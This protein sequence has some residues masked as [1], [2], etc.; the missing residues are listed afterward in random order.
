MITSRF[1]KVAVTAAALSAPLLF[2]SAATATP[3]SRDIVHPD[4]FVTVASCSTFS[5]TVVYAPGLLKTTLRQETAT[6]SGTLSNC[7]N[8]GGALPGTGTVNGTLSGMSSLNA[9]NLSGSLVVSLPGTNPSVVS[10][11]LYGTNQA[12]DTLGGNVVSG[13]YTGGIFKTSVL[14]VGKTGTGS[15]KYPVTA[16]TLVNTTPVTVSQNFG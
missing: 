16:Q 8:S 1:V 11:L 10:A 9:V 3:A 2:A 6:I 5:G 14:G 7:Q 13:A 12:A 15:R 4:G